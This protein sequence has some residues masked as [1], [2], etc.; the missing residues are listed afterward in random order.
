LQ[1]VTRAGD[2][3]GGAVVQL[4]R[5]TFVRVAASALL[6]VKDTLNWRQGVTDEFAEN[7]LGLKV[8]KV[9]GLLFVVGVVTA[10]AGVMSGI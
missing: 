10:T 5:S 3:C 7:S 4:C 1:V 8:G 9:F 2:Q 6:L